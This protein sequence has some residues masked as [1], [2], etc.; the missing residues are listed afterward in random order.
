MYKFSKEEIRDLIGS[1]IVISIIFIYPHISITLFLIALIAVGSG[2]IFHELAHRF[3]ARYYGA[4][5][6][7]KAWYEGLLLALIL[8]IVLGVTLIAPG[9]V[10]IY[11]DHLTNKEN[12]VIAISGP[13]TNILLAFIFLIISFIPIP[14]ISLTGTV[15]FY[16]NLYLAAFNLLPIPPLDGYKV[17]TWNP[18]IWAIVEIPLVIY[19]LFRGIF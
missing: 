5:S 3:V 11:K 14:L 8:K 16:I 9:A 12:G 15:G 2:F 19:I 4:F 7:F 17:V 1:V 6:M 10:Y 13:L 18:I